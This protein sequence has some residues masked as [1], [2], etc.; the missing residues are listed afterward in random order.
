V[1]TC[2]ATLRGWRGHVCHVCR[3]SICITSGGWIRINGFGT[4]FWH[5]C[6]PSPSKSC[7]RQLI[8]RYQQEQ[9]RLPPLHP[10]SPQGTMARSRHPLISINHHPEKIV[11]PICIAKLLRSEAKKT[12]ISIPSI[13]T[14]FF[15][16]LLFEKFSKTFLI[17]L[18]VLYF[19]LHI[20]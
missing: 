6:S 10:T 19:S 5:V 17:S 12:S 4:A 16:Q 15:F 2:S 13:P 1:R 3:D 9:V 7:V 18:L 14:H 8:C 20:S 11:S